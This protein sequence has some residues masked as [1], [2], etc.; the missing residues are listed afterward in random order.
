MRTCENCK[1][2][3]LAGGDYDPAM[4]GGYT[5]VTVDECQHP[6]VTVD[7]M[8]SAIEMGIDGRCKFFELQ[9]EMP[10]MASYR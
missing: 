6:S 7:D 1:Y 4:G 2:A 10:K 8:N 5:P 9:Q 3:A